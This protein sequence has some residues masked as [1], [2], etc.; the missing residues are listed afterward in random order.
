MVAIRIRAIRADC[1]WWVMFKTQWSL[2]RAGVIR[3][4]T[5]VLVVDIMIASSCTHVDI[6]E[7]KKLTEVC[8]NEVGF[9]SL[10]ANVFAHLRNY[11]HNFAT[12][13]A[14]LEEVCKKFCT[15]SRVGFCCSWDS[16]ISSK[17]PTFARFFVYIQNWRHFTNTISVIKE[18]TLQKCK[19]L[20]TRRGF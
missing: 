5:L 14:K 7:L 13:F 12:C 16:K 2:H 3:L 9:S 11:D 4:S 20:V 1:I 10:C 15:H 6:K 8:K 19:R 18:T 17:K